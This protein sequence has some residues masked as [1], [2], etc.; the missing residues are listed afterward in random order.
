[1][2]GHADHQP[3]VGVGAAREDLAPFGP[4]LHLAAGH[5]PGPDD[6]IGA[7]QRLEQ[8]GSCSGWCEPSA[9]IST[10]TS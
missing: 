10:M 9:S 1:M 4:V 5:P 2:Q 7:D 6:Q 8:A 3:G